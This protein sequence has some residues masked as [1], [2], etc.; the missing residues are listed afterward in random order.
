[1]RSRY[2]DYF[3]KLAASGGNY[4][5]LWIGLSC[6]PPKSTPV[7]L[8]GGRG[9]RFGSYSL[10]AAWRIDYILS[11]GRRLGIYVLLCF[12]AQQSVQSDFLFNA[13]I[14]SAAN[15]GPLTTPAA[16]WTSDAIKAEFKQRLRYAVSA[17]GAYTSVFS[18]QFYN[19]HDDFPHFAVS[20]QVAWV[21]NLSAMVREFDPYNHIVHDS[22]GGVPLPEFSKSIDFATLHSYGVQS[23]AAEALNKLPALQRLW[24]KPVFWGE[25]ALSA[26]GSTDAAIWWKD[27]VGSVHLHNALWAS[28]VSTAAGGAM[29]WWWHEFDDHNAYQHFVPVRRFVERLPLLQRR[30]LHVPISRSNGTVPSPDRSC[31]LPSQPG[32]FPTSEGHVIANFADESAAIC[33]QHCCANKQCTGW[34]FTT[35]QTVSTRAPCEI[36]R[37]C[38]WLKA[39]VEV[40]TA[41]S[42]QNTVQHFHTTEFT[43]FFLGYRASPELYR[44]LHESACAG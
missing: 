23:F 13:S 24:G 19:E 33:Q 11:L 2:D 27:D 21:A 22:F 18:W 41:F 9:A 20:E 8:A 1:M 30:W 35:Y 31:T 17:Y 10:E 14:Y 39:G 3:S 42:V 32:H 28:V 12:E 5:R 44:W 36:G 16:F 29:H 34:I 37:P 15:G 4:V 43:V 6:L 25:T 38:C 26:G 40:S 7:S